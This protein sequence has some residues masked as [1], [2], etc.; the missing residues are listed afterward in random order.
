MKPLIN[1]ATAED[2]EKQKFKRTTVDLGQSLL[3]VGV[4][5][6][7]ALYTFKQQNSQ[8]DVLN[9]LL[10]VKK[11]LKEFSNENDSI[12]TISKEI[13]ELVLAKQKQNLEIKGEND[14][15]VL[16]FLNNTD[17]TNDQKYGELLR[18]NGKERVA[19]LSTMMSMINDPN[20]SID[21][22][23]K[24]NLSNSLKTSIQK[25]GKDLT[26]TESKA[27]KNIIQGLSSVESTE[28]TNKYSSLYNYNMNLEKNDL[29]YKAQNPATD[30]RN[31]YTEIAKASK[32][33]GVGKAN[34][35]IL[36]IF[37]K[38][39]KD[40]FDLIDATSSSDTIKK[41]TK[42]DI[43][44][45][46]DRIKKIFNSVPGFDIELVGV[47]E[48][49]DQGA[50][51]YA[52]ITRNFGGS[53][54]E[55]IVMP[56]S[57]SSEGQFG[58]K[59]KYARMNATMSSTSLAPSYVLDLNSV[60]TVVEDQT[61]TQAQKKVAIQKLMESNQYEDAIINL[62]EDL[63]D[64]DSLKKL[65]Q[66]GRNEL[67]EVF[68]GMTSDINQAM[69]IEDTKDWYTSTKQK[70]ASQINSNKVLFTF[71]PN[72][73]SSKDIETL[74]PKLAELQLGFQ[75]LSGSGAGIKRYEVNEKQ[76]GVRMAYAAMDAEGNPTVTPYNILRTLGVSNEMT[77]PGAARP[78]QLFDKPEA[79]LGFAPAN[80]TNVEAHVNEKMGKLGDINVVG[81]KGSELLNLG[82]AALGQELDIVG[83]NTGFIIHFNEQ[84]K[85]GQALGLADAMSYAG[86]ETIVAKSIKKNINY[87]P[88][89]KELSIYGSDEFQRLLAGQV[90]ELEGEGLT[91]FFNKYADD[92]GRLIIGESS[93]GPDF[94]H[95][96]SAMRKLKLKIA[97][98]VDKGTEKQL[99]LIGEVISAEQGSKIFSEA[100][101]GTEYGV[102]NILDETGFESVITR[103]NEDAAGFVKLAQEKFGLKGT[104][105]LVL[106]GQDVITKAPSYLTSFMFGGLRGLG[107]EENQLMSEVFDPSK[108]TND[109]VNPEDTVAVKKY[110]TSYLQQTTKNILDFLITQKETI[111][112]DPGHKLTGQVT[113]ETIGAIL[114]SSEV[115]DVYKNEKG[116]QGYLSQLLDDSAMKARIE[117]AGLNVEQ[118]KKRARTGFGFGYVSTYAGTPS[119]EYKSKLARIEPRVATYMMGALK[120]LFGMEDK[121]IGQFLGNM[122]SNV[123][124]S[125]EKISLMPTLL[126]TSKSFNPLETAD[127]QALEIDQMLKSG[128]LFNASKEFA[129]AFMG[130]NLES[131]PEALVK[132]FQSDV[133]KTHII[134]EQ[135]AFGAVFNIEDLFR[136]SDDTIDE[137]GLRLLRNK[138]GGKDQIVLPMQ[139]ALEIV[140]GVELKREGED[141]KIQGEFY[142]KLNDAFS[143]FNNAKL[144][145]NSNAKASLIE[146]GLS[147]ISGIQETTGKIMRNLFSGRVKGSSTLEGKGIRLGNESERTTVLSADAAQNTKI[148]QN[149]NKAL[150][151][152]Q[153]YGVFMDTQAFMNTISSLT[154]EEK[155]YQTKKFMLG[156]EGVDFDLDN[157][158]KLITKEAAPEGIRASVFRNPFLGPT[159]M[160]IMSNVFR[161]DTDF[162]EQH[163]QL[164]DVVNIDGE[165]FGFRKLKELITDSAF[166]KAATDQDNSDL[167]ETI[168]KAKEA[169]TKGSGTLDFKSIS[170]LY[171]A[172]EKNP[173]MFKSVNMD[174]SKYT[175]SITRV[176]EII[177]NK[178]D[179]LT[180][181]NAKE[182]KVG[183]TLSLYNQKVLKREKK[184]L[185][186]KSAREYTKSLNE[187]IKQ[188]KSEIATL[189]DKNTDNSKYT[190]KSGDEKTRYKFIN[191]FIERIRNK[192]DKG[193]F[194]QEE[195]LNRRLKSE[196]NLFLKNQDQILAKDKTLKVNYKVDKSLSKQDQNKAF[197]QAFEEF[198][199]DYLSSEER[200]NTYQSVSKQV[201]E[202][203][204]K[205]SKQ[206]SIK[207]AKI[208]SEK[209][210]DLKYKQQMLTRESSKINRQIENAKVRIE[211]YDES[212]KGME[213]GNK[214]PTD[215]EVI[216]ARNAYINKQNAYFL[217]AMDTM[218]VNEVRFDMEGLK[219][220]L[221]EKQLKSGKELDEIDQFYTNKNRPIGSIINSI[222]LDNGKSDQTSRAFKNYNLSFKVSEEFEKLN[223]LREL[224]D[225]NILKKEFT[226]NDLYEKVYKDF[227]PKTKQNKTRK[228]IPNNLTIEETLKEFETRKTRI[229]TNLLSKLSSLGKALGYV[230]T[231]DEIKIKFSSTNDQFNYYTNLLN[232]AYEGR[233][234]LLTGGNEFQTNL[235]TQFLQPLMDFDFEKGNIEDL[236]KI[237]LEKKNDDYLDIIKKDPVLKNLTSISKDS[238]K[239][240]IKSFTDAAKGAPRHNLFILAIQ[241]QFNGDQSNRKFSDLLNLTLQM[242]EQQK[243]FNYQEDKLIPEIKQ[244]QLDRAISRGS[245]LRAKHSTLFTKFSEIIGL[246]VS[247]TLNKDVD[248]IELNPKLKLISS[249]ISSNTSYYLK[250]VHQDLLK[251]KT[252][253]NI[254]ELSDLF[255]EINNKFIDVVRAD[256]KN[257]SA[258]DIDISNKII[259]SN[260]NLDSTFASSKEGV[261]SLKL[262]NKNKKLL[263]KQKL[264]DKN[265]EDLK[266]FRKDLRNQVVSYKQR[267]IKEDIEAL[268]TMKY[269]SEISDDELRLKTQQFLEYKNLLK[270]ETNLKGTEQKRL[271]EINEFLNNTLKST[272]SIE[273]KRSKAN[274]TFNLLTKTEKSKL[275]DKLINLDRYTNNKA[276]VDS[277]INSEIINKQGIQT[278]L[279]QETSE[280]IFNSR[281]AI[282]NQRRQK[283]QSD[284]F[285]RFNK[286]NK[287][288]QELKS[289]EESLKNFSGSDEDKVKL[290]Q[291]IEEQ[292][293][294]INSEL[295]EIEND[296]L[297]KTEKKTIAKQIDTKYENRTKKQIKKFEFTPLKRNDKGELILDAE[298]KVQYDEAAKKTGFKSLEEIEE[299][300]NKLIKED[301][302]RIVGKKRKKIESLEVK[303]KEKNR[304]IK[305]INEDLKKLDTDIKSLTEQIGFKGDQKTYKYTPE[306]PTTELELETIN[307]KVYGDVNENIE[308]KKVN[309]VIGYNYNAI[310]QEKAD[311]INYKYLKGKGITKLTH[312]EKIAYKDLFK[313][314]NSKNLDLSTVENLEDLHKN[315]VEIMGGE[316]FDFE[317]HQLK[318]GSQL[319]S[320]ANQIKGDVKQIENIEEISR[321]AGSNLE[322]KKSKLQE[323][324]NRLNAKKTSLQA[325]LEARKQNVNTLDVQ[326]KKALDETLGGYINNYS[327]A[328]GSGS[329]Q[330]VFPEFESEFTFKDLKGNEIKDYSIKVRTDLSRAMVGDFDA[331]IYQAIVHDKNVVDQFQHRFSDEG[332]GKFQKQAATFT[333]NMEMIKQGM[334]QFGKRLNEQTGQILDYK[335]FRGSEVTKEQILKG[336]VGGVDTTAKSAVIGAMY[337]MMNSKD[338]LSKLRK[339]HLAAQTLVSAAQEIVV[340]KSKSLEQATDVGKR[341]Q[342]SIEE[343]FK[344]GNTQKFRD[345]LTKDLFAGTKFEQGFEVSDVTTKDMPDE[346]SAIHKKNLMSEP[347]RF[348]INQVM[349]GFEE[350]V[351]TT[352]KIG[353]NKL[354]SDKMYA[355]VMASDKTMNSDVF[356]NLVNRMWMLESAVTSE[357]LDDEQFSRLFNQISGL[358]GSNQVEKT[359]G[360][361]AVKEAFSSLSNTRL[362]TAATAALGAS[363]LL[364]SDYSKDTLDLEENFSDSRVGQKIAQ[365]SIYEGYNRDVNVQSNV[366]ERP[367]YKDM[368]SRVQSPGETYI[369]KQ[370]SF[371]MKGEVN[372]LGDAQYLNNMVLSNGGTSSMM[373][374]DNRMPL[375][376]SYI[377]KIMG[378]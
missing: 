162:L 9:K 72:K 248:N 237:F 113:E 134:G 239:Q 111:N 198:K 188:Y 129:V 360:S 46:Y 224:S 6:A 165:H 359:L 221:I 322:A 215:P 335:T 138:I 125:A 194:E 319:F 28:V 297:N 96:T 142:R 189:K 86:G 197:Y 82:G 179:K 1:L 230:T 92:Q 19:H 29:I 152:S 309:K 261:Q 45:R 173:E 292:K 21:E 172:L 231:E 272:E 110:Q 228:R 300:K 329:G 106:T 103:A 47:Q 190:T 376:G 242:K 291:R 216:K 193:K 159:H 33:D 75:G 210:V 301:I 203:S 143:A 295:Y 141:F 338:D 299:F 205:K 315:K 207:R 55:P 377:D 286:A 371:L 146:A 126:M 251:G 50:S 337:S 177:K 211:E 10:N 181:L 334:D 234:D 40:I 250:G 327:R 158:G 302:N 336:T 346:L 11:S 233:K 288:I 192:S 121:E 49:E 259:D 306:G 316:A 39:D 54:V 30:L 112:V 102:Q 4:T 66:H 247:E 160:A 12:K 356:N 2:E 304:K 243:I 68:R 266:V 244:K 130:A 355:N 275:S 357:Q 218:E 31:T 378:E 307:K 296:Q 171:K 74:I 199:T 232:S 151:T 196:F 263:T 308:V 80:Q 323:D 274:K 253:T 93:I 289:N 287:L 225:D 364:S 182:N 53:S 303:K 128:K 278:I 163:K 184:K 153:G 149:L 23:L 132:F 318:A 84:A 257:K 258:L 330:I 78:G 241:E 48:A 229:Q 358:E 133:Y 339:T 310:N 52:K 269:L 7:A 206:E 361:R 65:D 117:A 64:K 328:V 136:N 32:V 354:A 127:K 268:K 124:G 238:D 369:A 154:D 352:R 294:L 135:E 262:I 62:M 101:K 119:S 122:I 282:I 155:L 20:L 85:K 109:I 69:S 223:P 347:I 227:D 157:T 13:K 349:E 245:K 15:K 372:S 204:I 118:I 317:K 107:F 161:Y 219:K 368:V 283:I 343:A 321:K 42:E 5:G 293:N 180:K 27:I 25:E 226:I 267:I 35:H 168:D 314:Y 60:K 14:I 222:F 344:T 77:T 144:A 36:G 91:N 366:M 67:M 256:S 305:K 170:I 97:E 24:S 71:D 200:R 94:I 212:V 17:L 76:V 370:Q 116:D 34:K 178:E 16:S 254:N 284:S 195:L 271:N 298:G 131:T 277:F 331:D 350:I 147:S 37:N 202:E 264:T 56:L 99:K 365:K 345:F 191:D 164:A 279:N 98:N 61:L 246:N 120:S 166:V 104:S 100:I 22:H 90:V 313:K 320:E 73:V 285:E 95:R 236:N 18:L 281:Q 367:F 150:V 41:K 332:I 169:K 156:M 326:L 348:D 260:F 114:T 81:K 374:N 176:D 26:E 145:K 265:K 174:F 342:E 108:Y 270:D 87:R 183:K 280:Q 214:A 290:E 83:S 105:N 213:L 38:V 209:E 70:S 88:D 115:L 240:L 351:S 312:S 79:F 139:K 325:T 175:D 324:L 167:L 217:N 276:V 252:V 8:S 341:Y 63:Y 140:S 340:I 373:V 43:Q 123:E 255:T 249:E 137:E 59:S 57:L 375:T 353:L 220:H 363:Y 58:R 89:M 44:K 235:K 185:Q 148:I 201:N 362:A 273:E 208:A 51:F 186:K 3:G 311:L 333:L 187:K